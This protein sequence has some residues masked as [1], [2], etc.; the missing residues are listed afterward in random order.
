MVLFVTM[1][2]L[3]VAV[4]TTV[5]AGNK[6]HAVLAVTGAVLW[7]TAAAGLAVVS[8]VHPVLLAL[9][10]AS[11]G[12][13]VHR[14]TRRALAHRHDQRP[15]ALFLL[16]RGQRT[17]TAAPDDITL[18]LRTIRTLDREQSEREPL[19]WSVVAAAGTAATAL[20][21]Y[22]A[23]QHLI[24]GGGVFADLTALAGF[25]VLATLT[26][27]LT[28]VAGL[29]VHMRSTPRVDPAP[30][31]MPAPSE[32]PTIAFTPVQVSKVNR[33]RSRPTASA[34]R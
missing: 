21:G 10:G 34:S 29:A 2:V 11:L 3:A 16:N 27:A 1:V 24:A 14:L 28:G 32:M 22:W 19:H 4:A 13:T 31:P 6:Q 9:V 7:T 15:T 30:P 5:T 8:G 17:R 18:T 20:E 25:A 33:R 26:V 12:Y 23:Y